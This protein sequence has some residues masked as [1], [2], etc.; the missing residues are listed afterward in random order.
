MPKTSIFILA[1]GV[2]LTTGCA[3]VP[4]AYKPTVV[5]MIHHGMHE[6]N[7]QITIEPDRDEAAV[8]DRLMFRVILTNTGGAPF[9]IPR[10]PNVL[11]TWVYPDGRRDNF[12]I[13]DP[14]PRFYQ[15][16]ELHEVSPGESF[17]MRVPIETYYFNRYGVTE[18]RAVARIPRSTNPAHDA[19]WHGEAMS[20]AY[21][22]LIKKK[23]GRR[24]GD[25]AM[26]RT[27][28]TLVLAD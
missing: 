13:D 4:E 24:V 6:G 21:G 5:G 9:L 10:R 15:A 8:G 22:V 7:L 23:R 11:F 2:A 20:N 19:L 28:A 25:T 1:A 16:S 14:A 18:F 26:S 17:V 27:S 12:V 3:S